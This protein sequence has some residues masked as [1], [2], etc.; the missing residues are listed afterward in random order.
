MLANELQN[1]TLHVGLVLSHAKKWLKQSPLKAHQ[2]QNE[3]PSSMAED[4]PDMRSPA[5]SALADR[6]RFR[7]IMALGLGSRQQTRCRPS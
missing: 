1:G 6:Q 4:K 5:G 7:Q 3:S 2:S